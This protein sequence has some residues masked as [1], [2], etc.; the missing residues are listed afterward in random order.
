MT[1]G[2]GIS[3]LRLLR[4]SHPGAGFLAF[5]LGGDFLELAA[6]HGREGLTGGAF[7]GIGEGA[8]VGLDALAHRIEEFTLPFG[9]RNA[10]L[11]GR[12]AGA[13]QGVEGGPLDRL[14]LLIPGAQQRF[15]FRGATALRAT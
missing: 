6:L 9:Q 14:A 4:F 10:R 8:A 3:L 1:A 5:G 15:L 13:F 7:F 11:L 12:T 2:D